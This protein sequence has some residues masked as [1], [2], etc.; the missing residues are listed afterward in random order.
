M[1]KW[2]RREGKG[3]CEGMEEGSTASSG[4]P[5]QRQRIRRRRKPVRRPRPR[6][7][8]LQPPIPSTRSKASTTFRLPDVMVKKGP[9]LLPVL[10]SKIDEGFKLNYG[11][12]NR[13]G[14]VLT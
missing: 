11:P 13:I 5:R 3:R 6:F 8:T 14:R 2:W 7:G 9:M 4:T 1:E 10:E 12:R